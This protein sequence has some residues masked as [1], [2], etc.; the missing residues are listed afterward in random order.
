MFKYKNFPHGHRVNFDN[1]TCFLGYKIK[2]YHNNILLCFSYHQQPLFVPN[3]CIAPPGK[4][5]GD[6][7]DKDKNWI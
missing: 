4:A 5:T 3:I 2:S 1:K 7:V 6:M